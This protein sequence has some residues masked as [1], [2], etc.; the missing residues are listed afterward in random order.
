MLLD[1]GLPARGWVCQTPVSR[2]RAELTQVTWIRGIVL[3]E[4]SVH[5]QEAVQVQIDSLA[6][7]PR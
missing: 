4:K 3:G 2:Q 5:A 1:W 6:V 7:K